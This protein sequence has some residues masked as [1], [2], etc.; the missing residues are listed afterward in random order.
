MRAAIAA[1]AWLATCHPLF[2]QTATPALQG[3]RAVNVLVE[4]IEDDAKKCGITEQSIF[5]AAMIPLSGSALNVGKGME[6]SSIYNAATF[7]VQTNTLRRNADC[8]TNTTIRVYDH[9]SAELPSLNRSIRTEVRLWSTGNMAASSK[10]NHRKAVEAAVEQLTKMFLSDW[11]L[12]N[13]Q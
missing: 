11:N 10:Q 6:T 1:V 4:Y 12:S 3:L 8:V 5:R 7:L 13:K 2:A 9:A